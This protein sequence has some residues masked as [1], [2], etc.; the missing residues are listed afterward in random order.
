[1]R[2]GGKSAA[3]VD[4]GLH[5]ATSL[6]Q[7]RTSLPVIIT[8]IPSNNFETARATVPDRYGT[9]RTVTAF[10]QELKQEAYKQAPRFGCGVSCESLS[11]LGK[12]PHSGKL[13]L[14]IEVFFGTCFQVSGSRIGAQAH[15]QNIEFALQTPYPQEAKRPGQ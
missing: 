5:C 3:Q 15:C 7:L 8:P 12:F 10:S 13:N 1:M 6:K 9:T 2:F 11:L 4:G 14:V